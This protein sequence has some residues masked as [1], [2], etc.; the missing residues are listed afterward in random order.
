MASKD[1]D[2]FRSDRTSPMAFLPMGEVAV[3]L[4]REILG[5]YEQF[6]RA[7]LT[8]VQSEVTLWTELATKLAGT[9][10]IPEAVEAYTK[11]LSRQMQ[12]TAEDGQRLFNGYQETSQRVTKSLTRPVAIRRQGRSSR[13][14]HASRA[15]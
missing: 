12:M 2:N 7:W 5:A 10:S 11:C 3:T 4:Q 14:R 15:R 13:A 1:S 9:R 8:R 6:N